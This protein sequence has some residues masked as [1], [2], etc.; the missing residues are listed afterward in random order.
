MGRP[1]VAERGSVSITT[2]SELQTAVANWLNRSDQTARIPEFIALAEAALNRDVD[3]RFM[4]KRTTTTL[5]ASTEYYDTPD[6]LLEIRQVQLNTDP[7]RNLRMLT[8]SQ[9]TLEYPSNSV[10][11]PKAVAIIGDELR[12]RPIPDSGYTL[13][14][15]YKGRL[16][17]LSDAAPSNWILSYAPDAYLFGSLIQAAAYVDVPESDLGKWVAGYGSAVEQLNAT[18]RRGNF[19]NDLQIRTA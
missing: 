2:Y 17:A 7:V 3:L 4:Q 19:G 18:A 12:L 1:V 16:T 6:D 9:L 11:V 5:V 14:I 10:G 15:Q 8:P 13:E